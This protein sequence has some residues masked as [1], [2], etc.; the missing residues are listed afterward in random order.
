MG[1]FSSA[2]WEVRNTKPSDRRQREAMEGQWGLAWTS[3]PGL[4]P[5]HALRLPGYEYL[6]GTYLGRQVPRYLGT[7]VWY[8]KRDKADSPV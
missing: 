6:R 2:G 4:K 5:A 1:V 7:S 3:R 8:Q